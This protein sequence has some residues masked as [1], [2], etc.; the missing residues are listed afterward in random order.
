M[1]VVMVKIGMVVLA[2]TC[3]IIALLMELA[4]R[5]GCNRHR[6]TTHKAQDKGQQTKDNGQR[7]QGTVGICSQ[8]YRPQ[9]TKKKRMG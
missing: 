8:K 3:L 4:I 5:A 1:H 2:L 7:A 6:S 9:N